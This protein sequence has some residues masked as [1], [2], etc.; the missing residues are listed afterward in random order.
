MEKSKAL[1]VSLLTLISLS[2][3]IGWQL[4]QSRNRANLMK[5]EIGMTKDRVM[6]IMGKPDLNEAY[7]AADKGTL[8]ILFYYTNRKWADGNVTK[9]ECI[10][11]VFKNDTLIG[12][13][14]EFYEKT[15]KVELEIKK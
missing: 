2:C 10:P 12:W 7:L 4:K 11:I 3:V 15:L 5:L 14:D 9:D 6:Q 8:S 1:I 13:G